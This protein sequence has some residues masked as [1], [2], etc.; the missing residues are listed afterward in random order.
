MN[1]CTAVFCSFNLV[2][3]LES[4][5]T[6]LPTYCV[7][8]T[9]N[10]VYFWSNVHCLNNIWVLSK[11]RSSPQFDHCYVYLHMYLRLPNAYFACINTSIAF[12]WCPFGTPVAV[13]LYA[14]L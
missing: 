12:D 5:I 13:P 14:G 6:H 2:F 4:N 9:F 11:S 10:Y 1:L 3:I 8:F 7:V